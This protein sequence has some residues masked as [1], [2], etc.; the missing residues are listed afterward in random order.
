M[1]D[2]SESAVQKFIGQFTAEWRLPLAAEDGYTE[3]ELVATEA[4]IGVRLPSALR[5]AYRLFGCRDD[6]VRNQDELIELSRLRLDTANGMLIFRIENQGVTSWGVRLDLSHV[7]DPPVLFRLEDLGTADHGWRPFLDRLSLACVEMVLS[8]W[9]LGGEDGLGDNR[10]F[11]DDA[12]V[13]ALERGFDR[14]ELLPDYPLWALPDGPPVRWFGDADVILR[15]DGGEWVWVR[16]K[17]RDAL[18]RVR[19]TL[20]GDWLMSDA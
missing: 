17:T 13:T 14:L 1:T 8:E 11:V 2:T 4:R 3:A 18:D 20:P 10:G 15:D 6:L 12:D 5:T 9:M 7:D 19:R 16:A